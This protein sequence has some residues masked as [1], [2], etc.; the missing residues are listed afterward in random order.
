MII[1]R[2]LKLGKN[3]ENLNIHFSIAIRIP[4]MTV[5][6]AL[7][8]SKNQQ[9]PEVWTTNASKSEKQTCKPPIVRRQ[10]QSLTEKRKAK[11]DLNSNCDLPTHVGMRRATQPLF[12]AHT[13]VC[14]AQIPWEPQIIRQCRYVGLAVYSDTLFAVSF[15]RPPACAPHAETVYECEC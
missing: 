15:V 1:C 5:L 6:V 10:W 13:Y 11:I 3:F 2:F 12:T 9:L 4:S 8:V 14:R 7:P